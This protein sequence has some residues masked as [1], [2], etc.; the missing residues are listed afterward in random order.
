MK[1]IAAFFLLITLGAACSMPVL[2]ENART[3]QNMR[4]AKRAARQNQ[5]AMKK[6]AKNQRKAMKKYQKQQRRAA[7]QQ[8]RRTR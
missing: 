1:R 2:A 5:K 7:K 6:V 4:L 8:K 3:K